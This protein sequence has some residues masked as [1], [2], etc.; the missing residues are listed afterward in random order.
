[1]TAH[2]RPAGPLRLVLTAAISAGLLFSLAACGKKGSPKA[3]PGQESEYTFPQP[4]PSPP[5]VVPGDHTEAE[6][7]TTPFSIFSND[8]RR[9]TT[10][11]E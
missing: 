8:R 10:T 1:M 3:P 11:V 9:R 7:A 5:T 2:S 6:K 4:Y